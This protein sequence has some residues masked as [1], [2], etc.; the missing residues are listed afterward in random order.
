MCEFLNGPE[1][2]EVQLINVLGYHFKGRDP[3]WMVDI[4]GNVYDKRIESFMAK[5]LNFQLYT[6][7]RTPRQ[8]PYNRVAMRIRR[9]DNMKQKFDDMLASPEKDSRIE[10]D[11]NN[12]ENGRRKSRF[13]MI[14]KNFDG[15][16]LSMQYFT[17]YTKI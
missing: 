1:S 4:S 13:W 12:T 16:M 7:A 5:K 2:G 11:E 9:R 8:S 17:S 15:K 6:E 14:R 10:T 3:T